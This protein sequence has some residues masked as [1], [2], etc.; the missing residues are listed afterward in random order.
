M[1]SK[2]GSL[3]LEPENCSVKHAAVKCRTSTESIQMRK[4][5]LSTALIDTKCGRRVAKTTLSMR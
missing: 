1:D 3:N 2:C 5:R 4:L